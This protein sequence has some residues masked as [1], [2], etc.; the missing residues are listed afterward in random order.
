MDQ[1]VEKVLNCALTMLVIKY[2]FWPTI[3][4]RN[5]MFFWKKIINGTEKFSHILEKGA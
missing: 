4:L 5:I 3:L 1:R 2:S